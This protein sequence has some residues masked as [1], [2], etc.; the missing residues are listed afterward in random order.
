MAKYTEVYNNMQ[1]NIWYTAKELGVAPATM[2]A[3]VNR[4]LVVKDDSCSPKKYLKINNPLC[5]IIEI[6]EQEK[7][8]D[9][10]F[11]LYKKDE[12]LGMFCII[13]NDKVLDCWDNPYDLNNVY[14]L[15]VNKKF[16]E[17]R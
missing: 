4:N 11:T 1:D 17:L 9:K 7:A 13:K 16:F 10:Y 3:L 2:T 6:I 12:K 8:L 15:E 14:K 5:Q